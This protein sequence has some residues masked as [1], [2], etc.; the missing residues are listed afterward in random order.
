ML[1]I[2]LRGI[3]YPFIGTTAVSFA[4]DPFAQLES[5]IAENRDMK[6]RLQAIE[7]PR[8]KPTE[9]VVSVMGS[10]RRGV[11][12][13]TVRGLVSMM[14]SPTQRAPPCAGLYPTRRRC[15]VRRG[16]VCEG[17][18]HDQNI[19]QRDVPA[20]REAEDSVDGEAARCARRPSAVRSR[21]PIRDSSIGVILR[22][23]QCWR[24]ANEF[25]CEHQ[26]PGGR[27]SPS[28]GKLMFT[29]ELVSSAP[30]LD[31]RKF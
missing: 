7:A 15:A 8:K 6:A 9:L 10:I 3:L 4:M 25:A 1:P 24:G 12:Y 14:L 13:D 2:V 18:T 11:R 30:A 27:A 21:S 28:P 16:G 23:M 20:T 26:L 29:R 19:P 17:R 22:S 5:L 31:R